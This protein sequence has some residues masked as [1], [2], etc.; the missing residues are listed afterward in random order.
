MRT[1]I[2]SIHSDQ[3]HA[4]GRREETSMW[5]STIGLIVT[6]ALSLL[7][8]P[9]T[10]D[11]QQAEKVWRISFLALLPGEDKTTLM[12]ALLERLH[13]L[14]YSEGKNM[15]FEY[16][17]AEGRPERLPPVGHGS[18]ASQAGRADCGIGDPRGAGGEGSHHDHPYRLHAR[19]RPCRRRLG[20]K[21]RPARWQCH[22]PQRP[23]SG[24]WRQAAATP[25]GAHPR[26]TRYRGADEPG[27]P[28]HAAGPQGRHDS[29]RSRAD[30]S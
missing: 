25:A 18:R 1:T 26:Q 16:R 14:G 12:Q 10:A 30:T 7:V 21:P 22:G 29:C 5:L 17:S 28:L 23:G 9:L 24:P 15:T 3:R 11:A 13:E 4:G 19:R 27:H 6:L 20:R 2:G 8:A